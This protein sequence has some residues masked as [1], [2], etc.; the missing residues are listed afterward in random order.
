VVEALWRSER[1]RRLFFPLA[2][3]S[4]LSRVV[5]AVLRR[6]Y[7]EF[8]RLK[9]IPRP[10]FADDFELFQAAEVLGTVGTFH[11]PGALDQVVAELH[12]AFDEVRF[13]PLNV[14]RVSEEVFVFVVQFSGTGRGSG[15]SVDRP[16]AHV[17]SIGGP[18]ASRLEV[19]WEPAEALEAV[20][21]R[22]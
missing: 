10:F 16:I 13:S 19:Y 9:T 1:L 22:A 6:G 18:R 14:E 21:A 11:G 8:N 15:I 12:D 7:A 3:A 20:G 17:W 5:P 2:P 4:V